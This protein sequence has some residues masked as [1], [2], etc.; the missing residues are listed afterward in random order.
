MILIA[1]SLISIKIIYKTLNFLE[2]IKN[3]DLS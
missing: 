2:L 3:K 1:L